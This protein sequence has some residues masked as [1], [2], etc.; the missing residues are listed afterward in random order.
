VIR[1]CS[2]LAVLLLAVLQPSVVA[3]ATD[4]CKDWKRA[5]AETGGYIAKLTFHRI[6]V[7]FDGEILHNERDEKEIREGE[8]VRIGEIE[9]EDHTVDFE[10][11]SVERKVKTKVR[12]LLTKGER[13]TQGAERIQELLE[14]V[15]A[16]PAR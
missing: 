13:E 1:T 3:S 8:R 4:S 16:R 10:V 9:C 12:L 6:D 2:S 5:T 15:L 14:L 11:L 7:T